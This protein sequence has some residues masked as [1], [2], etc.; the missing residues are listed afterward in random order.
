MSIQFLCPG[1]NQPIE[2]DSEFGGAMVGCPYCRK[3]VTAPRE[4]TL[5]A[6]VGPMAAKPMGTPTYGGPQAGAYAR[7]PEKPSRNIVAIVA[8]CFSVLSVFF[9]GISALNLGS[10]VA[11]LQQIQ[12]DLERFQ[13][14]NAG[15]PSALAQ[16]EMRELME[17]WPE[18]VWVAGGAACAAVPCALTA[19]ICGIIGVCRPRRRG[20]AITALVLVVA[21]PA[22][23][24]FMPAGASVAGGTG[25][26]G[27][28]TLQPPTPPTEPVELE[29]GDGK[30]M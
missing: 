5:Q 23:L 28:S 17:S 20:W 26:N 30:S 16:Q 3:T 13:Q 15:Q 25:S 24:C 19:L 2:V 29:K 10:H 7:V 18:W 27:P 11:E 4:S 8:F 14:R 22:V 9:F 21:G 12:R 1:C 6:G